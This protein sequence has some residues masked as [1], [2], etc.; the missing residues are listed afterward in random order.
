MTTTTGPNFR[1][2]DSVDPAHFLEHDWQNPSREWATARAIE[3]AEGGTLLEVGPGPGV[4]YERYFAK[5][6][7]VRY[8]GLEGS[9]NLC[10]ALQSRF[11]D[12]EWLNGELTALPVRHAD[13]VYARHVME[14]QPAIEPALGRLLGAARKAVVLTW[15]RPPGPVAVSE[16]WRDVHCQTFARTEI[17]KAIKRHRWRI[18]DT[19]TFTSG[20]EAWVL[21]RR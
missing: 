11:P 18:T 1:Y 14:H 9:S 12:A 5:A 16:V 13:V 3:A 8:I 20:D 21:K 6:K 19:E 4:D 7:G 2:W 17:M 15:Y 10:H